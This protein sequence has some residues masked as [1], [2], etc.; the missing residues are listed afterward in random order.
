M[1]GYTVTASARVDGAT[2]VIL[3]EMVRDGVAVYVVS[4]APAH[5][6]YWH[7]GR[8]FDGPDAIANRDGARDAFAR[9]LFAE[10]HVAL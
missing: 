7:N 8:Y 3:G 9:I 6:T 4:T 2:R 1:N 10:W 5:G